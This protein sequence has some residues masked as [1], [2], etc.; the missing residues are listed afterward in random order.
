[1]K[2]ADLGAWVALLVAVPFAIVVATAAPFDLTNM[3]TVDGR[4][5]TQ[6]H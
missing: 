5:G 4:R 6:S 2:G 3:I 1:M